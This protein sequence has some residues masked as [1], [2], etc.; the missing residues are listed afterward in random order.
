MSLELE[1]R[2]V[3]YREYFINIT[4]D[5]RGLSISYETDNPFILIRND[6]NSPCAT[7]HRDNLGDLIKGLVLLQKK[8]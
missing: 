7:C 4:D 8:S 3:N 2:E 6:I 1:E 5:T